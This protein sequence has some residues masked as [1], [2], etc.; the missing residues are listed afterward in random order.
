MESLENRFK[1]PPIRFYILICLFFSKIL[2]KVDTVALKDWTDT[3]GC[4]SAEEF[5]FSGEIHLNPVS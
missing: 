4:T 2:S 5:P 3:I 1:P